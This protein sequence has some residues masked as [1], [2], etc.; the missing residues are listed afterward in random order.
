MLKKKWQR[1]I[2]MAEVLVLTSEA[3]MAVKVVPMLAPRVRGSIC[4]TVIT[5]RPTRGVKVEVVT[6][7]DCTAMVRAV[8][9][10]WV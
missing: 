1:A 4:S 9:N 10:C 3:R 7:E 2:W 6:E 8:P 5:P